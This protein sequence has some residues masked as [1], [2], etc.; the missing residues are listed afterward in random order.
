MADLW[1]G[2]SRQ[3][4]T[5]ADAVRG[6]QSG[7]T[8]HI[9]A[10]TYVDD[11]AVITKD[12]TLIGEGHV[13]LQGTH[14][15]DNGKA[16]L[17]VKGN[18]TIKNLELA[19]ATVT[20]RNGAAIRYE[21]GNLT[22]ID[23]Y[24]HDNED[25]ILAADD[26]TGT[27]TIRHS[28]FARNGYG[29]GLS[30]AI[31]INHVA[32][33]TVTDSYFHDTKIGHH[34]KSRA[35][36]TVI[37]NNI[38]DDGVGGTSSYAVD[39]PNGG[40]AL[41]EGNWFRQ[42][43]TGDADTVVHFGGENNYYANS[44][45]VLDGNTLVD[46]VVAG[47]LWV[48]N[49][50]T[51]GTVQAHDNAIFGQSRLSL[52]AVN[53]YGEGR[54]ALSD[55][56]P[57]PRWSLNDATAAVLQV[58]RASVGATIPLVTK[59][60]AGTVVRPTASNDWIYDDHGDGDIWTFT[61]LAINNV[62]LVHFGPADD[63]ID[64]RALKLGENALTD[65][66]VTLTASGESTII[67]VDPDAGGP[68]A[69]V[70][71]ATAQNTTPAQL[72]RV[73]LLGTTNDFGTVSAPAR[74]PDPGNQAT[75]ATN[76]GAHTQYAYLHGSDDTITLIGPKAT[77]SLVGIGRLVFDDGVV[78]AD[79]SGHLGQAYRLYVAALAR[80]PDERGLY[81][82]AGA[83]DSGTSLTTLAQNF[84]GSAEFTQ[85]YGNVGDAQFVQL[86][87]QNVLHRPADA[88]GVAVQVAALG[89]GLSRAQLLA[90]FSESAE[91]VAQTASHTG[92]GWIWLG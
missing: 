50:T 79:S 31:Y 89:A 36:A 44:R 55:A 53:V 60:V 57:L 35:A 83:L 11:T 92:G 27:I 69:A 58:G 91:N 87:Y 20:D 28:E 90:N 62:T 73:L 19:G 8:I 72:A 59:T 26:P 64:L 41:V 23:S 86:L 82:Q 81:A 24:I 14:T 68:L 16:L 47:G 32:Q 61:T 39:L 5:I 75:T 54:Y 21:S 22:V 84:I 9:E 45:L 85:R 88:G 42:A 37:T 38:F 29:D 10:G 56:P 66:H 34:L 6:S 80:A 76:A 46:Q 65:G 7:D 67:T 2:A 48:R 12:L 43:A 77:T 33:L 3:F 70:K 13:V 63:H 51:A 78:V 18:I 30:H 15:I 1:V 40:N 52:G 25:G 49:E 71:L 17:V 74:Y 4:K